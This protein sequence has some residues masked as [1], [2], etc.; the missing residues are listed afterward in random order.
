MQNQQQFEETQETPLYAA[1]AAPRYSQADLQRTEAAHAAHFENVLAAARVEA[2]A[3]RKRR[4]TN[5]VVVSLVGSLF[6][7]MAL[8]WLHSVITGK[9]TGDWANF[10]IYTSIFSSFGGVAMSQ[11][12]KEAAEKLAQFND[13][14][15]VG[16]LAETLESSDK[17]LAR[18]SRSAL[19]LLLPRLQFSDAALL[20]NEQR[21]ILNRAL[22]KAKPE[23]RPRPFAGDIAG[24]SA[25]GQRERGDGSRE[26][27]RQFCRGL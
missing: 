5:R 6:G 2:Q 11:N 18:V 9:D 1:P 27:D 19:I 4:R 25:G 24:V 16:L 15:A 13:V 22:P 12:H 14:R 7:V 8:L 17:D 3:Y 20:S 10:I 23:G 26:T 21:D